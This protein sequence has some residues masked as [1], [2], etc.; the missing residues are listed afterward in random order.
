MK[1]ILT[2]LSITAI[3]F[4]IIGFFASIIS[5]ALTTGFNIAQILVYDW[6]ESK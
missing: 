3:P 2:L 1:V 5:M 4:F 6:K